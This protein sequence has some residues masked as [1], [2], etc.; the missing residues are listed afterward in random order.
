MSLE[1][2]VWSHTC[3]VTG[4]R[5]L[6][7]RPK[8]KHISIRWNIYILGFYIASNCN[9]YMPIFKS[10]EN[11]LISLLEMKFFLCKI[12]IIRTI[13]LFSH[14]DLNMLGRFSC[15]AS[16]YFRFNLYCF[17]FVWEFPYII[18]YHSSAHTTCYYMKPSSLQSHLKKQSFVDTLI[19]WHAKQG[20]LDDDL[21]NLDPHGLHLFETYPFLKRSQF[22]RSHYKYLC[23][24][25]FVKSFFAR[26]LLIILIL[27]KQKSS[28]GGKQHLWHFMAKKN[29]IPGTDKDRGQKPGQFRQVYYMIQLS[30]LC[31]CCQ[32][33][34]ISTSAEMP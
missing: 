34:T 11:I 13:F 14:L 23:C 30:Y 3:C 7:S 25:F 26:C 19:K 33:T 31:H 1:K 29:Q 8:V 21:F 27:Q 28:P 16:V 2:S 15:M 10:Y 18:L 5:V 22:F 4:P 6:R 32:G 20:L 17:T 12:L 9:I 24:A